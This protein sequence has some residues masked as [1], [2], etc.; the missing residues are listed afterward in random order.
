MCQLS[1][2]GNTDARN[3]DF[4]QHLYDIYTTFIQHLYNFHLYNIYTIFMQ[5]LCNLYINLCANVQRLNLMVSWGC[6]GW[7][8]TSR[9]GATTVTRD[10]L[11]KELQ[12]VQH[13][14]P[15]EELLVPFFQCGIIYQET[16]CHGADRHRA[17]TCLH[18]Y[19]HTCLHTY[20]DTC[21]HIC[22]R[23][24]LRTCLR[25]CPHTGS[26]HREHTAVDQT[27]T[28]LRVTAV[29]SSVRGSAERRTAPCQAA[30]RSSRWHRPIVWA[31][32]MG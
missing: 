21:L 3:S 18:T 32:G 11:V 26:T 14:R 6:R 8:V 30:C 22:L 29:Q 15:A 4:I 5:L 17:C 13:E 1:P 10:L 27:K 9:D 23:T 2:T 25:T 12:V 19:L 20:P 7:E 24:F 16:H 31:D 28:G